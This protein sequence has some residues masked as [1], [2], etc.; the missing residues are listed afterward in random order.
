[1]SWQFIAKKRSA[2]PYA[3]QDLNLEKRKMKGSKKGVPNRGSARKG[4]GEVVEDRAD[5]RATQNAQLQQGP[6]EI[7]LQHGQ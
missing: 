4:G 3:L 5:R 1:M 7:S 6:T 2:H